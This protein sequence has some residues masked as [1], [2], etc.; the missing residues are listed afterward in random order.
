M[1]LSFALPCSFTLLLIG[2]GSAPLPL[3]PPSI[4]TIESPAFA[5]GASIPS[6]FT[7][8]GENVSPPL[9]VSGVPSGAQ[10]LVLIVDDPDSPSGNFVHWVVYNIDPTVTQ[11]LRGTVP[12]GGTDGQTSFGEERY[13]GPCPGTGRHRYV[14]R[15]FAL[16]RRL[17]FERT[18]TK[19]V[20]L[21]S[22]QGH[23]LAET[24]LV[25]TYQRLKE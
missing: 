22:L 7:C 2:C 24:V 13:G 17:S 8:D 16:D 1:R 20:L 21:S 3:V 25:G 5:D 15:L 14:F 4:M 11:V 6:M 19:Q 10:S 23:V 12:Q 18:P 9:S